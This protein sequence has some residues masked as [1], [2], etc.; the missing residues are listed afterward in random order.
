MVCFAHKRHGVIL[1]KGKV[2]NDNYSGFE[3]MNFW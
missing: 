3:P 2:Y 1:N